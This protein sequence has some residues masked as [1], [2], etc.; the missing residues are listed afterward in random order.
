MT[1]DVAVAADATTPGRPPALE[2]RGLTKRYGTLT[3]VSSVS[4]SVAAGEILGLL[5]PNGSGKS[6]TLNLV[7]GF[8]KP[9]AG[10]VIIHGHSLRT[11]PRAALQDVGGLVEG[12][13]F[14][15]Y[16][17][18]RLN[19]QM[20]ARLRGLP[21]SRADEV[22]ELV[23]M[24][25]AAE[26]TF[27]DYSQGMRQRLGVAGALMHRPRLIVLDEPT[28]GLDPAGTREM[29]ALLP[30]VA[31][32][33]TTVVLASH[34]LTEVEQVCT[35]VA[36]MQAGTIL[37]TGAVEDLLHQ[38][39]RWRVRLAPDARPRAAELLRVLPGVRSVEAAEDDLLVEAETDGESLNRA[40]FAAG[41]V[42]SELEPLVP[43]LES[44][45]IELTERTPAP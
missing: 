27:G 32:E 44:V 9:T 20:L 18:G 36:I 24:L 37:T 22:L 30:R 19:L 29:R 15:P 13:A 31:A 14:Y 35:R 25:H 17:S 16:L 10:E 7:M 6:T 21:A 4:L 38:R 3:A 8:I 34:L 41:L 40:L 23:G 28:S 33:G 45:F 11:A 39:P 26:R 5:G 1:A 43:S 2:L 12:S 42:A